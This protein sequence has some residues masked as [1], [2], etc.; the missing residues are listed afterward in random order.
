M[1][2]PKRE[3]T[4]HTSGQRFKHTPDN[5]QVYFEYSSHLWSV[6]KQLLYKLNPWEPIEYNDIIP[7][8]NN[9]TRFSAENAKFYCLR[10]NRKQHNLQMLYSNRWYSFNQAIYAFNLV[11]LMD[12]FLKWWHDRMTYLFL[13]EL[14]IVLD[15]ELI[16]NFVCDSQL[17]SPLPWLPWIVNT[18]NI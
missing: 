12:L 11:G 6:I 10:F 1:T 15:S 8:S 14:S 4:K 5:S 18:N 7:L 9:F 16:T 13:I 2:H 17:Q 3:R